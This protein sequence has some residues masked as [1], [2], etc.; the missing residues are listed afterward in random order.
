MIPNLVRMHKCPFSIINPVPGI[1]VFVFYDHQPS[2]HDVL[3]SY[4]HQSLPSNVLVS[5]DQQSSNMYSL[6][7][8]LPIVTD[9]VPTSSVLVYGT[10]ITNPVTFVFSCLMITN[11][12]YT[13]VLVSHDR[14][15]ISVL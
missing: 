13:Y 12:V 2:T 1:C 7:Q 14:Q 15:F 10:L 3:V 4:G 5:N 11:L 6:A 8:L 9:P